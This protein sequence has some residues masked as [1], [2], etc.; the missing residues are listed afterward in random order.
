[1]KKEIKST[2][3]VSDGA[4][5]DFLTKEVNCKHYITPEILEE[6]GAVTGGVVRITKEQLK[7]YETTPELKGLVTIPAGKKITIKENGI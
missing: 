6:V 2:I 1:M 7:Q 5:A 4:N 3:Q